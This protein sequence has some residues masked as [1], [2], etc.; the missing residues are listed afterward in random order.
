MRFSYHS[1]LDR[2]RLPGLGIW[3]DAG[4]FFMICTITFDLDFV[5]VLCYFLCYRTNCDL[6]NDD[7][8]D[9]VLTEASPYYILDMSPGSKSK[10][11]EKSTPRTIKEHPRALVKPSPVP[12]NCG[13]GSPTDN[14]Y[15]PITEPFQNLDI[16]QFSSHST[17]QG[18]GRFRISD[19]PEDH[20]ESSPGTITECDS[21]SNNDSCSGESE[22]QKDKLTSGATRTDIIP[23]CD[24]DKRDK[25]RQK[26]E[27][28][29]QR[30]KERR[31]Q[32][33]RERCTNF[34]KSRKLKALSNQLA[35]MGFPVDRA[36][37]ALIVNEGRMEESVA[38]LLQEGEEGN[39]SKATVD[40]DDRSNLKIDIMDEISKI[41]EMEIKYNCT[42]LEVERAVVACEGDLL[43]AEGSL[44]LQKQA[45]AMAAATKPVESA[46]S[47]DH[48]PGNSS[49]RAAAVNILQRRSEE[50]EI[51][52]LKFAESKGIQPKP[53]TADK[54]ILTAASTRTVQV[55]GLVARPESRFG[56]VMGNGIMMRSLKEEPIIVMRRPKPNLPSSIADMAAPHPAAV[57]WYS[58]NGIPS[59]EVMQ[60][61]NGVS[62]MG[63]S[64]AMPQ[65]FYPQ[66]NYQP[67]SSIPTEIAGSIGRSS[68]L[69][70]RTVPVAS[71]PVSSSSLAAPSSLGLF[72][73]WG[74]LSGSSS[75]SSQNDWN[76][77]GLRAQLDYTSIDWSVDLTPLRPS[78]A[79]GRLSD[80]WSTMFMGGNLTK[81][82]VNGGG[83]G[84]HRPGFQEGNGILND[85]SLSAGS[86]EWSNPFEGRD[87]FR[88]P[89][90]YV[91]SSPSL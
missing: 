47:T 1:V 18:N 26:N 80:T 15:N 41:A 73:G 37:M 68:L 50:M 46:D 34:L 4:I 7:D 19:D 17:P 86:L 58:S 27:K 75:P 16:S 39:K 55:S 79:K 67:I 63:M 24:N 72:T 61:T 60:A 64:G 20:S 8:Y 12:S 36:A 2:L 31:A 40:V 25:I 88:V 11:K 23:G 66:D 3:P 90:Q 35:A 32:E 48:Y 13:N 85:P 76:S 89:R 14:S 74:A 62:S 5:C 21:S 43:K 54:K 52:C 49:N 10:S 53:A 30:Q 33:L 42:K 77:G 44:K 56:S 57:G 71:A 78:S 82:A 83:T 70:N 87:L 29:H 9:D 69:W 45:N 38:W 28:K 59:M 91:S 81:P 65:D 51:N 84:F 22:D 6:T